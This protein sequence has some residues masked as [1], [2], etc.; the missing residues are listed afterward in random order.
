MY[1]LASQVSSS[2]NCLFIS[3]D[4]FF[5]LSCCLFLLNCKEFFVILNINYWWLHV[6]KIF[7]QT[8]ICLLTWFDIQTFFILMYLPPNYLFFTLW[9]IFIFVS[10]LK[11]FIDHDHEV[12]FLNV[13]SFVYLEFIFVHSMPIHALVH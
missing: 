9:L 7:S 13:K 5:L 11:S 8:M 12:L 2:V 4:P 10:C 3:F 1:L 6:I